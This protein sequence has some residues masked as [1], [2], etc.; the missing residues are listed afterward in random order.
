VH[1][2]DVNGKRYLFKLN[3]CGDFMVSFRICW[4]FSQSSCWHTPPR[5]AN[6]MDRIRSFKGDE[7]KCDDVVVVVF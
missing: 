5:L 4:M 1:A 2:V 6:L 3:L 7:V